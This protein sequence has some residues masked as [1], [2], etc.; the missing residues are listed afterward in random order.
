MNEVNVFPALLVGRD[1]WITF[2]WLNNWPI[3]PTIPATR[4]SPPDKYHS[5]PSN[6][7]LTQLHTTQAAAY[8]FLPKLPSPPCLT[9]LIPGLSVYQ[10]PSTHQ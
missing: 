7:S 8:T 4:T 10:L 1:N 9:T 3:Y 5:V 6:V 2:P